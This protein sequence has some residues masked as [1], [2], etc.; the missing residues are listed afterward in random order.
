MGAYYWHSTIEDFLP[1]SLNALKEH[2]MSNYLPFVRGSFESIIIL[3]RLWIKNL[4]LKRL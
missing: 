2:C 4:L 1:E 3:Q